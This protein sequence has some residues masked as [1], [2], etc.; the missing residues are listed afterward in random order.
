MTDIND[1]IK[2][3]VNG[4]LGKMGTSVVEAVN[5]NNSSDLIAVIDKFSNE[6]YLVSAGEKLPM[7]KSLDDCFSKHPKVEV[8]VDFTNAAGVSE[9]VEKCAENKV[10]LVSG[11]TGYDDSLIRR[12]E[13]ISKHNEIGIVLSPNFAIGAVLLGVVSKIIAPFFDYVDIV[14]SHHEEKLDSPSGTALSLAESILSGRKNDLKMTKTELEKIGGTRGGEYQGI[15]I[16]SVRMPGRVARHEI[17]FGAP[18]QTMTLIHDSIDRVNFMPGVLLAIRF[19]VNMH[20]SKP[21]KT[22]LVYGI[23]DILGL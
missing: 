11:S 10:N 2:V 15:R 12:A 17:V 8:V 6:D 5:N 7:Y 13:Y 4:A 3:V 23:E 9:A 21:P 19:V 18:G 16:H 22:R 14:E 1:K 20:R